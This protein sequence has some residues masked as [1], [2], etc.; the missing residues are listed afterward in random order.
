MLTEMAK[1]ELNM[2]VARILAFSPISVVFFSKVKTAD[3]LRVDVSAPFQTHH[4]LNMSDHCPL[5]DDREDLG[6]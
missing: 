5:G 3:L 6:A 2:Q 1:E 4:H